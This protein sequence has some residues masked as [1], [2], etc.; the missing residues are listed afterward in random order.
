[1]LHSTLNCKKMLLPIF[2]I[3]YVPSTILVLASPTGRAFVPE[4]LMYAPPPPSSSSA[5]C[6]GSP[7]QPS[8]A[9]PSSTPSQLYISAPSPSS[10]ASSSV[11]DALRSSRSTSTS[12]IP[13]SDVSS[14]ATTSTTSVYGVPPVT[15]KAPS[16]A[17]QAL[18]S[19]PTTSTATT[20]SID[21]PIVD[22]TSTTSATS[23]VFVYGAPSSISI[24]TPHTETDGTA[25]S[26]SS[27]MFPAALALVEIDANST[28]VSTPPA[29][30]TPLPDQPLDAVSTPDR[31]AA[32][33][34][35]ATTSWTRPRAAYVAHKPTV[36]V[37]AD[38]C[39]QNECKDY[40]NGQCG[41]RY[42]G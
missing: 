3:C 12:T 32:F 7:T 10:E 34:P 38:M 23:K 4:S 2:L 13:S 30:P 8:F 22:S 27:S 16:P 28:T 14:A 15:S 5:T 21:V 33:A 41:R 17:S 9:L 42:G 26:A 37:A 20:S 36:T 25:A 18:R 11:S 6:H 40:R 31:A 35:A 19:A 1:M 39:P 29:S 24:M